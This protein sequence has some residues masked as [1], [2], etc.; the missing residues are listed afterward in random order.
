MADGEGMPLV[1]RECTTPLDYGED[2][3]TCRVDSIRDDRG[4]LRV[5]EEKTSSGGFWL[6]KAMKQ[7]HTTSQFKGEVFTLVR[8]FPDELLN[9]CQVNYHIKDGGKPPCKSD[10]TNPTFAELDGFKDTAVK[11]LIEIDEAV[12]GYNNDLT[13]G[14][15]VETSATRWFPRKG[16]WNMDACWSYN[17]ACEFMP[18]CLAPDRINQSLRSFR[19]RLPIETQKAK[20][21]SG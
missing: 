2:N 9:G 19:P 4:F 14:M 5:H 16:M 1:E 8:N 11:T 12:D 18:F 21:Y 6:K 3:Y 17:R 15:D 13:T 20:E 7:I 10:V